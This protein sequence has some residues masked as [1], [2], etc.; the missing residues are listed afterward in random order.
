MPFLFQ[1]RPDDF[2]H[3]GLDQQLTSAGRWF[4]KTRRFE[5]SLNVHL[6]IGDVGHKLHLRLR[7]IHAAHDT[8]GDVL[9]EMCIRDSQCPWNRATGVGPELPRRS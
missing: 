7:L 2:R 3:A 9:G 8:K 1:L 6:V 4:G 5:R